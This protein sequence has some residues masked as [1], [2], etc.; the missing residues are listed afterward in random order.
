MRVTTI[1]SDLAEEVHR[2]AR[3]SGRVLDPGQIDVL[4]HVA[5][6]AALPHGL[7]LHGAVGRGKTWMGDLIFAALPEPKRR[8]HC[9]EFLADLNAAI[10]ARI[11]KIAQ[12]GPGTGGGVRADELIDSVVDGYDFIMFDDFHV[13]DVADGRLLDIALRRLAADGTF[14]LLTSNYAPAELLPD[15]IY[16]GSFAPTIALIGDR[17]DVI[18]IP[19]GLDHRRG[20]G[21]GAGFASGSWTRVPI[22]AQ[23]SEFEPARMDAT[24][25]TAGPARTALMAVLSAT[26]H[27]VTDFDA[28]CR[29][30]LSIADYFA[31]TS[32]WASLELHGVPSPAEI[33]EEAFQRFAFLID[34]LVDRDVVFIVE[35]LADLEDFAAAPNL[36][37]DSARLLSRLAMLRDGAPRRWDCPVGVAAGSA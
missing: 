34:A 21:H 5:G 32:G 18:E 23:T 24:A 36:P 28:L 19:A 29:T 26:P 2:S 30:P 12:L 9:H 22:A 20:A 27:P 33:D 10:A 35:S 15:P 37:R 1:P 31:L 17:C 25:R 16:H 8:L 7:Y 11:R 14:M 3:E 4:D 13:H 6:W